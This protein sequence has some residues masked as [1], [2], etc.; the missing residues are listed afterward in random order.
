MDQIEDIVNIKEVRQKKKEEQ[1]RMRE[2][3][4]QLKSKRTSKKYLLDLS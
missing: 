1:K 2:I 3:E 4:D